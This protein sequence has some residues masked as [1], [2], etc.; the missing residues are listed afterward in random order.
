MKRLASFMA[1]MITCIVLVTGSYVYAIGGVELTPQ[2]TVNK[3]VILQ[4]MASNPLFGGEYLDIAVANHTHILTMASIVKTAL[5]RAE[6]GSTLL[7]T[8]EEQE[9]FEFN[10]NSIRK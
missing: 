9:K 8:D 6:D 2:V 5:D 10:M 3:D 4:E 1:G 7:L